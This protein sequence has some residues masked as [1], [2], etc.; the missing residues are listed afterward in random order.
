MKIISAQII[1]LICAALLLAV[2]CGKAQ[3][4]ATNGIDRL[5]PAL[6]SIVPADAKL[7]QLADTPGTGTREGP[8][9]V[10]DGG[11][12]LYSEITA[13]TI[14]KWSSADEKV[15]PFLDKVDS[16]GLALDSQGRVVW[17]A[18]ASSGGE[19]GRLEKDGSRTVL[20]RD[21]PELPVKRPND[22]VY[23]SD[24]ALY[25]TDTDASNRRV[26]LFKDG[27][28]T[29]LT[30]D[31][32]YANGLAFA[33]G[34][35]YLYIN[36]SDKELITRFKVGRDDTIS[37]P[38]VMINMTAD[39]PCPFPCPAGYPDGMK[40]DLKGNIYSTGPGGIWIMSP[41]GKHLGTILVPNHPANLG[42]GGADGKTLFIGCRPGLYRIRL[43]VAGIKP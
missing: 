4:T 30:K 32:T 1:A 29:L 39:K 11:Y 19:I 12:L 34:E 7:E 41:S 35:K 8:V 17:A 27:K 20:V 36:D 3:S 40:V 18:R 21:S 14:D 22:L 26:Y 9:W 23:K 5:D 28:L 25:F 6:N 2:M 13:K 16:D 15:T 31:L 33:P 43:K 42:F 10:K 38:K 37:D 24:G